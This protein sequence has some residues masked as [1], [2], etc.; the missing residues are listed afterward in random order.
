L[1]L[2]TLIMLGAIPLMGLDFNHANMVVLP[3]LLG[4]GVDAAA[5]I[6][7]R[8]RQSQEEHAGVASLD[9]MLAGTGS[10]V[11][12]A[13]LT[14]VWGFSVMMLAEYRA[15]FGMGLIMTVGM[16]ATLILSLVTLPATLVL[17]KKAK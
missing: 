12:V 11:F 16:S 13:A 7:S 3:L 10:A 2:G 1:V 14:T 8:F 4:L 17:L 5:H 9:D 6:M 15:M